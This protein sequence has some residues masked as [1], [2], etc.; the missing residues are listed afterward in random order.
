MMDDFKSVWREN[1]A[2]FALAHDG[3][4]YELIPE[5][6]SRGELISPASW[7]YRETVQFPAL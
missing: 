7:D 3:S 1:A 5:Q 2:W 6:W 4:V